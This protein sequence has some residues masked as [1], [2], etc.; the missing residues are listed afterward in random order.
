M[1][2]RVWQPSDWS[3]ACAIEYGVVAADGDSIVGRDIR[4]CACPS[5][6][7]HR[8][9][10]RQRIFGF[11]RSHSQKPSRSRRR[12]F[13]VLEIPC[14]VSLSTKASCSLESGPLVNCYN[15]KKLSQ[16]SVLIRVDLVERVEKFRLA[17]FEMKIPASVQQPIW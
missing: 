15:Q 9:C 2:L 10:R 14:K 4:P 8:A 1:T 17:Q 13:C 3:G 7:H 5:I 12:S 16:P 6:V 11:L